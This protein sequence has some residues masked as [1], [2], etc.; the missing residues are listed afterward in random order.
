MANPYITQAQ[1]ML[2]EQVE[3]AQIMQQRRLAEAL[4]EQ[5][6][7][8]PQGQMVSGIYVAP[9][10]TQHL[11]QG[12]KSYLGAKGMREADARQKA[13][14]EALAKRQ[15]AWLGE[16]PTSKETQ[17]FGSTGTGEPMGPPQITQQQP[18]SEDYLAWGMRG[19]QVNPQMA[20]FGVSM[21]DRAEA[22]RAAQENMQAQMQARRE[23]QAAQL[24]AQKEMKE[25]QIQAQREAMA[26][27]FANQQSMARLAA[28][29]RPSAG[30][31]QVTVLGPS[32]EAIPMTQEQAKQSG[33]PLWNPT[34][35]KEAQKKQQTGEAKEQLS[36]AVAQLKSQYDTLK[37]GGGIPSREG[38][39]LSNIGARLGSSGLG[40]MVGGAI[41]TENQIA[42]QSIE[43]T[44]PLLLNLIKNATGMSAQQMNSNAEMQMYLKAA[45]D[46]TLSYEANMNALQNL[47]KMFGLG[48]NKFDKSSNASV[49]KIQPKGGFRIV[50]AE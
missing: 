10:W 42:R 33:M 44:R 30:E 37:S 41:G 1:P 17:Q 31:K 34:L 50:G 45:T 4:M 13:M 20:Q 40:Q 25:S 32:G 15:S 49:G 8:S 18:T 35:A 28:S 21:A 27:R 9:S 14:A 3:P 48:I 29:L 36:A 24:A 23:A 5:G 43:Q 12:L 7:E 39:A 19:M 38:G 16:M 22:R 2:P 26:E 47:D 11:A 6:R 46:P